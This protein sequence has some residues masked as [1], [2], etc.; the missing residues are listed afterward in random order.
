MSGSG[1]LKARKPPIVALTSASVPWDQCLVNVSLVLFA[2]VYLFAALPGRADRH[3]KVCN[4]PM[5][6]RLEG[7]RFVPG[8][9][10]EGLRS[11]SSRSE[12]VRSSRRRSGLPG[13]RDVRPVRA[14]WVFR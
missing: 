11:R 9:R 6:E 4:P 7:I 3:L 2:P 5:R 14:S 8:P 13:A 1:N 12:D 10:L